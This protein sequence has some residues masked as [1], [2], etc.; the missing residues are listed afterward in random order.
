MK[1]K[2]V[3]KIVPELSHELI[4]YHWDRYNAAKVRINKQ[5][6]NNEE[7]HDIKVRLKNKRIMGY[8]FNHSLEDFIQ[9][10]TNYKMYIY[11]S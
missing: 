6:A 4:D 7:H 10:F 5:R 2:A 11:F 8:K 9:N 1:S 3:E